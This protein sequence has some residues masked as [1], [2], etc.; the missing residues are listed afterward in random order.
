ML[1]LKAT[2]QA[3]IHSLSNMTCRE[4]EHENTKNRP[5]HWFGGCCVSIG[6]LDDE[7][8]PISNDGRLAVRQITRRVEPPYLV[9]K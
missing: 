7:R 3:F 4:C 8:G 9:V 6:I 2:Q 5:H 1:R